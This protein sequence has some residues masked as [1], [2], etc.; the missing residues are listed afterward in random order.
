MLTHIRI[1]QFTVV[2]KLEVDF[3]SGLTVITG[4]TGA[5]KSITL[6]ALALCL[7]DRADPSAIRP[8]H[9][10]A[11]ICAQFD[12]SEN[13]AARRWLEERDL[14]ADDECLLRRVLTR[15][16]RSRA[17]I[18]GTP[19][20]LQDCATLG[21]HLVDIHSQHAH[22]S[23]LRK[24]HQRSLLDTYAGASKDA[25][26]T[27]I[28]ARAWRD[29]NEQ[30][31]SLRAS[32][33]ES[34]DREQ[35]LR[36]QVGELD[37]LAL[38]DGEL[39]A[40]EAE[41]RQLENADTIQRQAST[42]IDLCEAQESG[43]RQALQSLDPE[44][45]EGKAVDNVRE[46]LD[47]AAIQLQEARSELSH[48][49]STR[50]SNPARLDE[51][52]SR[53]ETIYALARKHRVMPEALQEHHRALAE[54]F[55]ALDSSDERIEAL[56]A[57]LQTALESYEASA[58]ALSAS[59]KK[60]AARLEKAVAKLLKK[61]SMVNCEFRVTLET[62]SDG[63]PH[64]LGKEEIELRIATN[65][66]AEPQSLA[67]IAS[68]GELSRIS[69]AIQVATAGRATVPSM[70]FDEVDVGIGGAVAEVVGR[71]LADMASE[72]QVIC[73][74]HLPQ[75]AAQGAQHLLVAKTGRGKQLASS[76]ADLAEADRVEELSRML[77]GVTITESTRTHARELLESGRGG[78]GGKEAA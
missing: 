33:R 12:V 21:Q 63:S 4:E 51:V 71:L 78:S 72:A 28:A 59:R 5:G 55:A 30:L 45:H 52:S 18:N 66:G 39:A 73:V 1:Q 53:L 32:H 13:K 22:Q 15:E 3:A 58:K 65:P 31:E 44:L 54:E 74:T 76:I 57:E 60:A 40:L 38:A 36:Y 42:A 47:S 34:A 23:L 75:V 61:L 43:V 24:D 68:G 11:E 25:E 27:Q 17:Y 37:D 2:D 6:D 14:D 48:Y 41:Q 70:I 62:R 7:G 46:M 67:K 16:G 35:L 50:E 56:E 64:P 29:V 49:L 77:G 9:D 69:L 20:T 26:A 10:K 8:G 19:A